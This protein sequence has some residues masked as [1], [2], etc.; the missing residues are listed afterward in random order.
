M[1]SRT[2]APSSNRDANYARGDLAD[3][4]EDQRAQELSYVM[5]RRNGVT[6]GILRA[7]SDAPRSAL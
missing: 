7:G 4:P 2:W 6:R 1:A 3:L 5:Q